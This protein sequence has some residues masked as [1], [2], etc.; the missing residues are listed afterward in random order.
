MYSLEICLVVIIFIAFSA[1]N[2]IGRGYFFRPR[3]GHERNIKS[4]KPLNQG[5]KSEFSVRKAENLLQIQVRVQYLEYKE[6]TGALVA[7][8][9]K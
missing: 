2:T 6:I 8:D 5:D 7:P 9:E 1:L 3:V 4:T